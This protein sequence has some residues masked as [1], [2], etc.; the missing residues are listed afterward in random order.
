MAKHVKQGRVLLRKAKLAGV[1]QQPQH[2]ADPSA[3][4]AGKIPAA[5]ATKAIRDKAM[6]NYQRVVGRGEDIPAED[7][8]NLF[9]DLLDHLSIEVVVEQTPGYVSFSLRPKFE[10]PF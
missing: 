7:M 1:V 9:L 8:K 5:R 2:R 6:S 10:E 3:G 4:D